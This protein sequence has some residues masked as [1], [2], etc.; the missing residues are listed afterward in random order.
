MSK[1]N[2]IFFISENDD[3]VFGSKDYIKLIIVED[4]YENPLDW[5]EFE[6]LYGD[7]R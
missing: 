6:K 5:K 7:I 3:P 1:N 2:P 4:M